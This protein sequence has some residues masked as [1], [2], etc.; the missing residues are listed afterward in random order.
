MTM[1]GPLRLIIAPDI[2]DQ[3]GLRRY[4]ASATAAA[5]VGALLLDVINQMVFF[6]DWTTA[7]RS[8]VVTVFV[9]LVVAIP[10]LGW[11]GRAHLALAESRRDLERISRTDPLTGLPN[12]RALMEAAERGDAAWMVLVI[13]DID[14]FKRVNDTHGHRVGDALLCA[15]SRR[16]EEALG[17]FGLLGRMGGEEFA[18]I[19]ST[20]PSREVLERLEAMLG[21]FAA[22][23]MVADGQ[24]VLVTLSAGAA[25]GRQCGFDA[26]YS[27]AD[28]AL[29]AAKRAGRNRICLS[30]ALRELQEREGEQGRSAA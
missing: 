24:A 7:L 2:Q 27:E 11:I 9:A 10:I 30:D 29:Y 16:M 28:R 13:L 26:L 20:T 21:Q 4:V 17:P 5:V 14:N 25:I 3:R 12:R 15:A 18:F 19:S 1:R 6:I 23:P 22:G 8:W